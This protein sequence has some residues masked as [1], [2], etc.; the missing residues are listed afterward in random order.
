MGELK[1]SITFRKVYVGI[2]RELVKD[3]LSLCYRARSKRDGSDVFIY[4]SLFPISL[5]KGAVV[6]ERDLGTLVKTLTT[7]YCCF[8]AM[9][10]MNNR[11]LYKL[12]SNLLEE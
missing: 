1:G 4:L 6:E 2:S 7:E 9:M 10:V 11:F 5:T 8:K 12:F 3:T